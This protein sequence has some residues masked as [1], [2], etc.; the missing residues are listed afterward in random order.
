MTNLYSP[1]RAAEYLAIN[2]GPAYS[3]QTIRR[4]IKSEYIERQYVRYTRA[5][6]PQVKQEALDRIIEESRRGT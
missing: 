4:M 5:G 6:W 3:A 1:R 2:D